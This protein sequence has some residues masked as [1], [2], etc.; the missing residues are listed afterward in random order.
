MAD[1]PWR[2]SRNLRLK[3]RLDSQDRQGRQGS[4]DRQEILGRAAKR[5]SQER[6]A[7]RA[8]L[9]KQA[10]LGSKA[11]PRRVQRDSI[12]ATRTLARSACLTNDRN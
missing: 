1:A 5:A 2:H 4:Q 8:I 11:K 3:D 9:E 6:P 7:R 12:G 10:R